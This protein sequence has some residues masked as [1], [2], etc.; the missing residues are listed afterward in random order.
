MMKKGN[1]FSRRKHSIMN[2]TLFDPNIDPYAIMGI[3][4][5]Y[6]EWAFVD[7]QWEIVNI[8]SLEEIIGTSE[9]EQPGM[10]EVL[11]GKEKLHEFIRNYWWIFLIAF[12]CLKGK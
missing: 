8:P 10:S 2:P 5:L 11:V 9:Q 7:G 12:F 3:P 6:G 1:I 4:W